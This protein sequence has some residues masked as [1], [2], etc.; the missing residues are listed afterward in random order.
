M[1]K[2]T[3]AALL[4]VT[5]LTKVYQG[6]KKEEFAAL[7]QVSFELAE[8][9]TLSIVG[10]SGSGK[11]TIAKIIAGIIPATSGE[12]TY[13]G[14]PLTFARKNTLRKEI[15]YIFQESAAAL[16]PRM[17]I[18]K[19]IEEP[20]RLH[21]D[22][23]PKQREEIIVSLLND[24]GLSSDIRLRYPKELSG[25]QC[26]RIGIA[27]A[28]AGNPKILVCDEPTSALDSTI[29]IQILDLMMNL[30]KKKNFS[31]IFI[32]HSLGVAKT[33]SNRVLVMKK[34]EIVEQGDTAEIFR[35]PKHTY[36]Q[37]LLSSVPRI[38]L[39]YYEM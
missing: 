26:Q 18:Q 6:K 1:A 28:L 27:R 2:E 14:Q 9:E 38:E 22:Y 36:T 4:K 11:T 5:G 37:T 39:P 15:Q 33:I 32:T 21:Y 10:E 23:S 31:Y 16:D 29:Q 20:I 34:G 24:V 25:G 7:N 8:T 35:N 19:I 13:A 30:K 12:M 17:K 3:A